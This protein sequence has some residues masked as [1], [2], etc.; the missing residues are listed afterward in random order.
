MASISGISN[1]LDIEGLV[2]Q[3]RSIERTSRQSLEA[4]LTRLESRDS[5]LSTL[6][7]KLSALYTVTDRFTDTLTDVFASKEGS[8]SDADL[9]TATAD[10]DAQLGSHSLDV[11][12]L[13][14]ADVRVS[15]QYVSTDSDFTGLLTDQSFDIIVAHP[16]DAD[17]NNTFAVTVTVSAATFALTNE[18]VF[19][20]IA[21]TINAAV[22]FAISNGDLDATERVTAAAVSEETGATRL[23][24]R[25]GK[26]GESNALQFTD[27]NGLLNTLK[28]TRNNTATGSL[29]GYITAAADL[30]AEFVMD[31]LTFLRDSNVVS[32]VLTGVTLELHGT[33]TTTESFS[34]E[35]NTETV[36]TEIE[37]FINAYNE[38]VNYL[39]T[40]TGSG[41]DFRGDSTYSLIGYELRSIIYSQVTGASS[42]DYDRLHKIGISV[43]NDGTLTLEDASLFTTALTTDESFVSE[44][45]TASDG[46]AA[47]IKDYAHNYTRANG[48]ISNSRQALDISINY[49][50]DR[51]DD[52]DD[53][54]DRKVERFRMQLIRL[55]T[56][57][58]QVQSQSAF[59]SSFTSSA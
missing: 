4:N 8:T 1:G 15:S 29:G 3:Y 42:S 16:T 37:D 46:I 7:S 43:N 30:D 55:Q 21:D 24:L 25:S 26:S 49:Q 57:L 13:A 45:F 18:E 52:F 47:R 11:N 19:D 32:D 5:A 51:M 40:Q 41:S 22:S 20:G 58:T 35:A 10:S 6:D 33:T 53:R 50:T 12:R 54:L 48:L 2:T 14:S 34:V 59:L 38:T 31:G 56:V 36:Q 28:V 39:A 17:P 44:L 23:L 9:I 27:T